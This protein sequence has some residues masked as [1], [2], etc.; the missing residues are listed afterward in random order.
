MDFKI[1]LNDQQKENLIKAG[2]EGF[3]ED[4]DNILF[5]VAG[6]LENH[7]VNHNKNYT[8]DQYHCIDTLNDIFQAL[9]KGF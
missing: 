8:K 1:T 3:T 5:Y 4:T 7:L 9:Y 6:I 2:F